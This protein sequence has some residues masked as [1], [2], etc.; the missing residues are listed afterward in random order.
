MISFDESMKLLDNLNIEP[1]EKI[2]LPLVQAA[3]YVIA[4]DIVASYN[5]PE[6]P[7]AAMDG[8]AIKFDD[9][10][11]KEL[12]IQAINP[13]GAL[14]V[15]ELV[16]G[17]CIKTFTGSIMPKGSDTL[18]PIE[19]VSLK[20]DSTI[21]IEEEVP[22]GFSVREVGEN[23]KEGEVLIKKGTKIDFAEIGVLASLNV[24][25]VDVYKK[26]TVSVIATGEELL[27]LGEEQTKAS[28]I[29]S[30]NNYTIEAI[31][32][33]YG[34]EAKNLGCVGDNIENIKTIFKEALK[35]S[36]IIV[37]TGG[38]S[39]GDF[40]FVKDVVRDELGANVVFKGVVIKPG[41]HIM[42]ATVGNKTILA[43]PGFAY[44]STVTALLYLLPLIAKYQNSIYK[45]LILKAKLLQKYTKKSKKKEFAPCNVYFD[46][47]EITVDFKGKKDGTSAI[48][49]NMIG[50]SA[51]AVTSED[52]GDLDIGDY[53][54]L[55]LFKLNQN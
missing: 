3:G 25:S 42:L 21:Y 31:A 14:S 47:K 8:Y 41:Q 54:D 35:S 2:T 5:S 16:A 9:Q 50:V 39:V 10:S 18:I 1:C 48:M 46:N 32:N 33:K 51:L 34:A 40:D 15:E 37:S 29:R 49:T 38:V 55:F 22:F 7:T 36:D 45:P 4:E 52:Q 53:I 12:K 44:S 13:A 19:N 6:L 43:L 11:L 24:V 30:S 20:D 23:F 27:E 26:P 17:N 28:Q